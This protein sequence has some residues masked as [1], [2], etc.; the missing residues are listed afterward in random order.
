MNGRQ[1][2][3]DRRDALTQRGFTDFRNQLVDHYQMTTLCVFAASAG[4][5]QISHPCSIKEQG[6]EAWKILL[7][8]PKLLY[9]EFPVAIA[10]VTSGWNRPLAADVKQE[11]VVEENGEMGHEIEQYI[12]LMH[13]PLGVPG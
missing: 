12:A 2:L 8:D 10:P 4:A 1:R 9:Q 7:R 13:L 3:V 5:R 6:N 11:L